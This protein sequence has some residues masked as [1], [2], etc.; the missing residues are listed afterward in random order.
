MA[1][2]MRIRSVIDGV[3][4]A[5]TLEMLRAL[6]CDEVQG[7]HVA[8]PMKARDLEEWFERGGAR[9]LARSFD[10]MIAR[11]LDLED[12]PIDDVMKWASS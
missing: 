6:G 11:E 1:R 5:A 7:L 3:D 10:S 12:G 2:A 9:H 8:P 4:D